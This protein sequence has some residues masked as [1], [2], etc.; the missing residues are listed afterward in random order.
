MKGIFSCFSTRTP[1][2]EE[3]KTCKHVKLTN[4]FKW[5]PHSEDFQEQETNIAEHLKGDYNIPSA[6]RRIMQVTQEQQ[7]TMHATPF[8]NETSLRHLV[9]TNT[10]KREYKTTAKKLATN[11]SIG[12]EA[13]KK[14]LQVTTQKGVRHTTH[15]IERRLRTRQDQLRYN[16]LGMVGFIPTPSSLQFPR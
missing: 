10:S 13:A 9:S 6:N 16:Q 2:W 3:I 4:E 1:T 11:W 7:S 8:F 5:E 14:T 15:L 12:L